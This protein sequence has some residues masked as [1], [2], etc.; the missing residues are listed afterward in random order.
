[1]YAN[2]DTWRYILA[3]VVVLIPAFILE[4]QNERWAWRYTALI[5]LMMLVTQSSGVVKFE[6]F[7]NKEL[8]GI[9]Q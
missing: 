9:N 2:I 1:M 4:G 7:L 8:R 3:A 5:I 6:R